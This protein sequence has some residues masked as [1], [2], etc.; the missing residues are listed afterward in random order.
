M[1]LVGSIQ[2][3]YAEYSAWDFVE[4]FIATTELV[5]RHDHKSPNGAKIHKKGMGYVRT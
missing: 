4:G 1:W 5:E 3:S 2:G